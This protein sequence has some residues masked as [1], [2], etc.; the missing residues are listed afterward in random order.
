M[1]EIKD[2]IKSRTPC[3]LIMVGINILVFLIF[4]IMGSTND[5]IFMAEHGASYTPL[6]LQN[7]EYYRL[8]TCMFLH[9][10]IDHLF[11]NMLV[12]VFLGDTLEH[13][14]GKIRYLIIYFG[15]G[16]LANILS[17]FLEVRSGEFSVSAGASGGIFAVVGALLYI[18]IINKGKLGDI[19]GKRL[20]LMAALSLFQGFT[21]L[22]VDNA[23]HVGGL[24][25][26][27]ILAV[28]LYRKRR[29]GRGEEAERD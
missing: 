26:G 7:G 29:A 19:T 14:V 27:L 16:V 5:V 13:T 9:F 22:G 25:F 12:L 28:L 11:N 18:V 4:E 17:C 1:S 8:F 2:F 24:A 3:N 6:I 10:G 20:F 21:S 23:A 15:G